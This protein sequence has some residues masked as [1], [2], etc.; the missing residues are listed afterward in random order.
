MNVKLDKQKGK[1]KETSVIR[2]RRGK[3]V[4]EN[5]AARFAKDNNQSTQKSVRGRMRAGGR[6]GGPRRSIST[7]STI[8]PSVP[9]WAGAGFSN[10]FHFHSWCCGGESWLNARW[11]IIFLSPFWLDRSRVWEHPPICVVTSRQIGK[12][13]KITWVTKVPAAVIVVS[14]NLIMDFF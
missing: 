10:Q 11:V 12:V 5:T 3:T 7:I 4:K 2:M 14:A 8:I 13:L 1:C 9:V 6:G